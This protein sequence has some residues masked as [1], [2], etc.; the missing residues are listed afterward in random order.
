MSKRTELTSSVALGAER[1]VVERRV[2]QVAPQ[3]HQHVYPEP[4]A[5]RDARH[6]Q[7]LKVAS[8]D[9]LCFWSL[10]TKTR[11]HACPWSTHSGGEDKNTEIS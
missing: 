10:K 6:K 9:S 2:A 4:A 5:A 1:E 8:L 11:V 3:T 7:V